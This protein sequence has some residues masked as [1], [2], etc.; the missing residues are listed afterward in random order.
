MPGVPIPTGRKRQCPLHKFRQGVETT[1]VPP[2]GLDPWQVE[3]LCPYGHVF[4]EIIRPTKQPEE[5]KPGKV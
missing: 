2:I 5:N 3:F 1:Y 4:Y